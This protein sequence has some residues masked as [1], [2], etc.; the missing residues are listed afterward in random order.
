[1][2]YLFLQISALYKYEFTT[3]IIAVF[4]VYRFKRLKK[5]IVIKKI[6]NTANE[7]KLCKY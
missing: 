7:L 3:M 6:N 2:L 4:L 5:I 1:M